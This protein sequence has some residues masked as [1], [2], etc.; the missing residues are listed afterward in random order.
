MTT[1][2]TG[3]DIETRQRDLDTAK[4][5]LAEFESEA[6]NIPAAIRAAVENMDAEQ[7]VKLRDRLDAVPTYIH[8][9]RLLVAR[10]SVALMEAQ[11]QAAESSYAVAA[12]VEVRITGKWRKAQ[13]E[14]E[15]AIGATG[16]GQYAVNSA[17]IGLQDQR[18]ALDALLAE[19]AQKPGLAVRS[20]WQQA[21]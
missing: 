19:S 21:G 9:T 14:M 15:E 12:E 11:L 8:A 16:G 2:D 3:T 1:T 4:A 10:R 20:I 18:R 5:H 6:A 17:R 13:A 7:A